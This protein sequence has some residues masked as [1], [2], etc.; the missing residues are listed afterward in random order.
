VE[1]GLAEEKLPR[2]PDESFD[3][4]YLD[5]PYGTT[6]GEWDQCPDWAWLARET[7]RLLKRTG[8]VVLHG[9]GRMAA[10][11]LVAFEDCLTHRFELVWVKARADG[12]LRTTA[13]ISNFE[14][15][16]AHELIHVFKLK[17]APTG[18]LTFNR[19]AM[20]RRADGG[21]GTRGASPTHQGR[22]WNGHFKPTTDGYRWPVDVIYQAPNDKSELYAAKPE[23]LTKLLIAALTK[24]GD[25]VLDPFAGSGTTLRVSF[26]LGRRSYGIEA[27]PRIEEEASCV[28][29]QY[30]ET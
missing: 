15:L 26:S 21:Y 16:R 13:W 1:T 9:N 14:P 11:S 22:G 5:P 7:A 12:R 2:L 8:Q 20:H 18:E 10:R 23:D 4:I 3:L 27:F 24:P 6:A 25:S 28:V 29:G 19:D 30:A 17:G